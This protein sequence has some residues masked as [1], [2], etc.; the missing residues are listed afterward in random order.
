MSIHWTVIPL[1]PDNQDIRDWLQKEGF[2]TP[3]GKGRFPKLDELLVILRTFDN[4]PIQKDWDGIITI[5][6]GDPEEPGFAL[7]TG[8]ATKDGYF[9]FYF[10]G[11]RNDVMTMLKI[12]KPLS[13]ICGP[14]ILYETYGATPLLITQEAD[15]EGALQ[16][17]Q[18]R[19]R[20]NYS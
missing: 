16:D 13:E 9:D 8:S 15:M 20:K 5:S 7:M 1:D 19:F 2:D 14:L 12:L 4:I 3:A 6:L 10:E 11:W 18:S 17:W